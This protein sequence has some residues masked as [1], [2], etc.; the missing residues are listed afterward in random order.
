MTLS[1]LRRFGRR[2]PLFALL[3]AVCLPADAQPRP[4]RG[5]DDYVSAAVETWEIPGLSIAVVRGDSVVFAKGYGV[6][7]LGKPGAVDENTLFAIGSTTKAMTVVSLGML[8]D[9]GKVAW[10]DPVVQHLPGFRLMDPVAT[11][12]TTVRDM[13]THRTGLGTVDMIWYAAGGTVDDIVARLRYQPLAAPPRTRY[14]YQNA[15][16]AT[17][18]ALLAERSGMAWGRFLRERL[19]APIGMPGARTSVVGLDTVPNVAAPHDVIADTLRVL[20]HR[21]L[22]NIAPAGAVYA[23][24]REMGNWIRFL[25]DTGR[26]NGQ[27]LLSESS[28]REMFTPQFLVP[29]ES[30]YPTARL[31]KTNF[32]AYGLGWF[33]QDYRG[34]LV[35]MHTGS[36]DGMVAIVGLLPAHDVGVVVLANRDHAE[37]RHAL[38]WR[39]FDAYLGAPARDWSTDVRAMYAEM[40]AR[41]R[42]AAA[43]RERSRVEGTSPSLELAKYA[44]S[45]A[46]SLYGTGRVRQEGD[47][48]VLEFGPERVAD[49]EHW[50]YDTFRARWRD[51]GLGRSFVTFDLGHDGTVREM[52]LE[53][54]GTFERVRG[55]N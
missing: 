21:N 1:P 26:V 38:M 40:A 42:T 11:Q 33:L 18:G 30:F 20:P 35:A 41:G 16:Y 27:R 51:P 47:T 19:F 43:E 29:R 10:D 37:L 12:A 31:T 53:G 46:D 13:L 28:W 14:A 5:L 52:N 45:Y 25:L 34:E 50:H 54:M 7:E 9:S 23:G 8:V 6:R 3:A 44:A 55:E 15:M 4:L 24:A 49:L 22:D 39:V 2:L 48:L 32:S 17:A 36:I